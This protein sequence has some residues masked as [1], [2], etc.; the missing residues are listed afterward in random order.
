MYR[1]DESK[2]TPE[3]LRLAGAFPFSGGIAPLSRTYKEAMEFLFSCLPPRPRAWALCETYLEQATW[4]FRPLKRDEIIN[5]VLTPI[6]NAKKD[7]EDPNSETKHDISAHKMAVLFM[8]FAQGALVDLTLPPCNSEAE[9]YHFYARAALSLR[10]VFDS[11]MVETVQAIVLMAYYHSNAGKRY[12]LDS[13]WAL[14]SLGAKLAQGVSRKYHST[15]TLAYIGLLSSDRTSYVFY[16][17]SF[18]AEVNQ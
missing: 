5:D 15:F 9:N 6:Y 12:T 13:V 16:L 10:S 18:K 7:M 14:L 8:L 17:L 1:E 11:P 3:M 4:I 2:V